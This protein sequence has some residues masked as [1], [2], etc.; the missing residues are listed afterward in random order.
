MKRPLA[1][2]KAIDMVSNCG[3]RTWWYS[4]QPNDEVGGWIV[5]CIGVPLSQLK[6]REAR[7][8]GVKAE[9]VSEHSAHHIARLL[10]D[11]L[12]AHDNLKVPA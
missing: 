2:P 4:V 10:N 9:C 5:T 12:K 11:E 8:F 3:L 6:T 7:L 1:P